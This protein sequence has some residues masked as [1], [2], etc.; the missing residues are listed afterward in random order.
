MADG[1]RNIIYVACLNEKN[2]DKGNLITATYRIITA[3]SF[4]TKKGFPISTKNLWLLLLLKKT[5]G[6]ENKYNKKTQQNE[7][8]AGIKK[9]KKRT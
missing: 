4:P 3:S 5:N 2:N 1:R 8:G 6:A 7:P 9:Q